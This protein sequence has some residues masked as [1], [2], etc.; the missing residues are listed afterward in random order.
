MAL[1]K[2]RGV[3]ILT[4]DGNSLASFI[5]VNDGKWKLKDV[6]GNIE[7]AQS[8]ISGGGGGNGALQT[9]NAFSTTL[10]NVTD[11]V[12]NAS[13][14]NIATNKL[15]IVATDSS[16]TPFGVRSLT[17]GV[18]I[19]LM[20]TSTTA[21]GYVV[22]QG[23]GNDMQFIVGG[24]ARMRL[25]SNGHLVI[26]NAL[27]DSGFK[28][29]VENT[30]ALIHNVLVGRGAG[31][32]NT[33]VGTNAFT[34]A[35]AGANANCAFGVNALLNN[36]NGDSNSAFGAYS[37]ENN[38]I[39]SGNIAVGVA[40]LQ[41]NIT[42]SSNVAIGSEALNN[43]TV[44]N[45]TG[46]GHE[47]GLTN[48]SGTGLTAIGYQALRASTGNNNTA[49]GFQ[50]SLVNSSGEFNTSIGS[51]SQTANT[52]GSFN[53]SVGSNSLASNTTSS[54]NTA[55]GRSSLASNTASNNTAIGFEAGTTNTAGTGLTAIGYQAL[56]ASTG[57][58]N[59][60][61]GFSA[62]SV[63]STGSNNV[64]LGD[65]SG[66]NITTGSSNICI[67]REAQPTTAT[68]SNEFVVGSA[69]YN[70]GTVIDSVLPASG[71]AIKLWRVKVNGTDY[72]ILMIP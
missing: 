10:Q 55:I 3:D 17:N 28:L 44:S 68:S 29:H 38:T 59:T 43:N 4:P 21:T 9:A 30:D 64:L 6:N 19:D 41:D 15:Q 51:I 60:A 49:L 25:F 37:L 32:N 54:N 61:L 5:D 58:N 42:G 50:A 23:V 34:S 69:T 40:T 52:T 24:N 36:T 7:E 20:D 47:A 13:V 62:G 35:L 56:R 16:Q 48:V 70:A 66:V 71:S 2:S 39:G 72:S 14:L 46:V 22:L 31:T 65:S 11:G 12:G 45:N 8:Y 27:T 33:R 26:G 18:G 67:G 57:N 63:V 53:T 1:T